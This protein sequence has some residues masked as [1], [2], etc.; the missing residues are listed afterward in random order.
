MALSAIPP[1]YVLYGIVAVGAVKVVYE[2][3]FSP[4]SHIPG[5]FLAKFT[6]LYRSGLTHMGHVDYHKRRWHQ[7]W[8]LAVR[9][10]PNAISISDPDMIKVIYTTKNPWR[11]V[12][13][14]CRACYSS[15]SPVQCH[16]ACASSPIAVPTRC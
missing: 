6:D 16:I 11:K 5:P 7:K 12:C 15:T 13:S 1:V 9:V 14:I 8:G 10:G 4:L 2:L 3:F